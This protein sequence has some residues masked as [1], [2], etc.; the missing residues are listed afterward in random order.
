MGDIEKLVALQRHINILK[1]TKKK[2][3]ELANRSDIRDLLNQLK[4][5]ENILMEL[6]GQSKENEKSLNKNN[7]ILK[8][9]DYKLKEIEKNLYEGYITD[10]KQLGFLDHEREIIKKTIEE[11]EMEILTQMEEAEKYKKELIKKQEYFN[12][13]K[14]EYTSAVKKYKIAKEDYKKSIKDEEKIID[15]L[16]SQIDKELLDKFIYLERN[17][18]MA[19]AEVIEGRCTG[20]NV[21]LPTITVDRLKNKEEIVFCDN[22]DRILYLNKGHI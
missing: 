21:L 13:L 14:K 7:S 8:D 9:L 6:E 10:L 5:T 18:G 17:K 16:S 2:L 1:N 4:E 19:V 20:C 22:C 3:K 15:E 12:S 11:K